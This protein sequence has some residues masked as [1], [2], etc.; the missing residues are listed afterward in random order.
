[1]H[2]LIAILAAAFGF[3]TGGHSAQPQVAILPIG[4]S[5]P[6][7]SATATHAGAMHRPTDATGPIG[8]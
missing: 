2:Q 3:L 7:H 4:L 5:Q 1:M 8:M 6:V